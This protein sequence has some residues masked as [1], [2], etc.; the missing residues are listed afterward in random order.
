MKILW[1]VIFKDA[2]GG[3]CFTFGPD[4]LKRTQQF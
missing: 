4:N 1:D 2:E 3:K